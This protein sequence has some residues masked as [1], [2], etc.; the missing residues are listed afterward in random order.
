[1]KS[2]GISIA[3]LIAAIVAAQAADLP[4]K[5]TPPAPP[6]ANCY[7]S[8]STW[9]DSTAADCPLSYAGVT[10]YGQ[11]DAA[12][13]YETAASPFNKDYPQGVQEVINKTNNRPGWQWVPNGLSQSNIGVK[14]KEQI[15]PS[16]YIIGDIDAGFDPYSFR[17]ANG[18]ASLEDNNLLSKTKQNLFTSNGDSS[19]AGLIDNTRAYIGLSNPTFGAL[20]FGRQY[21][22][23]ND[24]VGGY[25]PFGGSYA[26]SLIG[27]SSTPVAGAGDTETARYNTS[28][29]YLI[30]YNGLRAGALAQVGGWEQG[31]GA[32]AAYQADLGFDYAGFSVDAV[33]AYA[34]D[35]VKLSYWGT[36]AVP[37][38]PLSPNTLT[39]TLSDI[40]SGVIGAKYKWQALTVYGGYAYDRLSSPSGFNSYYSPTST[41]GFGNVYT[42]NQ[43]YPGAVQANLYVNPEVLQTVWVGA[44]YGVLSNLDFITG[45][46]YEAQNNFVLLAAPAGVKNEKTNPACGPATSSA[47]P[48]AAFQGSNSSS[49]PGHTEAASVALDWR[50]VKRVDVYGGV[51]FSQVSGG[52]ANGFIKSDNTAYTGGVRVSF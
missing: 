9:L 43:G 22:F 23:S 31:N 50:P 27:N 2:F 39:A 32:Q 25:D 33:Y 24:L 12:G 5:K 44:K 35:A 1:M 13:G 26:F 52:M 38:P 49:C 15:A 46:Y 10:V 18:P 4:T 11:I 51:L 17:F 36:G 16:W 19:R 48:G 28:V 41:A 40:N 37:T 20:T 3:A 45:Y 14:I 34:K 29:K 42:F 47:A 21:A 7:A 30:N 6:A 8:F